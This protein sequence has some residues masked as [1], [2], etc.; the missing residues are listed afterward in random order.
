MLLS[1]LQ[2]EPNLFCKSPLKLMDLHQ[3]HS[4]HSYLVM[5][6]PTQL[7]QAEFLQKKYQML[8]NIF[9]ISVT[10]RWHSGVKNHEIWTFLCQKTSESFQKQAQKG[11]RPPSVT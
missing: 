1:I 7:S 5:L 2:G 3:A 6:R 4:N 8:Q 10:L 9:L 11:F